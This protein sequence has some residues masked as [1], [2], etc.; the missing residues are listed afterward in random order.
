MS[1]VFLEKMI[2]IDARTIKA[3]EFILSNG[4][5]VEL[6]PVKDGVKVMMVRRQ[7][8]DYEGNKERKNR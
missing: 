6:I 4:D 2:K 1:R 8:V 5:R 3:I 7:M